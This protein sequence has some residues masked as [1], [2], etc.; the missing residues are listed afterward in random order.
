[1]RGNLA[2]SKL[3]V[4]RTR[5]IPTHAGKPLQDEV[6]SPLVGVYPRACGETQTQIQKWNAGW[7]LSPRMRGKLEEKVTIDGKIGS[8]PAHAGETVSR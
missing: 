4:N 1:M 6:V 3:P 5:S 2:L 8:I 7:G